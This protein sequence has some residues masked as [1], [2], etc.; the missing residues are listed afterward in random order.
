MTGSVSGRG[1][2]HEA[3]ARIDVMRGRN[4][5]I[6]AKD[7]KGEQCAGWKRSRTLLHDCVVKPGHVRR[8][9]EL[10]SVLLK[11]GQTVSDANGEE[12]NAS[13]RVWHNG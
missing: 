8:L 13:E 4:S 9:D 10:A 3:I 5:K 1:A 12:A 7:E 6:G 11:R 2:E